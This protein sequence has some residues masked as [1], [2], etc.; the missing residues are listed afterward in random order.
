VTDDQVVGEYIEKEMQK[1]YFN[2]SLIGYILGMI[3]TYSALTIF[4][5]AQPALLYILPCQIV[6]YLL[7]AFLRKELTKMIH[8]DEDNELNQQTTKSKGTLQNGNTEE[9]EK[10]ELI[11]PNKATSP[12]KRQGHTQKR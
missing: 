7:A 3:A 4:Q 8:Y 10:K 1:F 2:Q 6:I 12:D 5:T 9:R 11:R